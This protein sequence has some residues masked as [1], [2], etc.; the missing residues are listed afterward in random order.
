MDRERKRSH[1]MR[2]AGDDTAAMEAAPAIRDLAGTP[3]RRA[4]GAAH[5]AARTRFNFLTPRSK[6]AKTRSAGGA[7]QRG[8]I[9]VCYGRVS[10]TGSV[11]GDSL[12]NRSAAW[13]SLFDGAL[14]REEAAPASGKGNWGRLCCRGGFS[15][16][17]HNAGPMPLVPVTKETAPARAELGPFLMPGR[18]PWG[19]AG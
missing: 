15:R 8:I 5:P 13:N 4:C 12:V 11:L 6:T 14:P 1:W 18:R 3:R 16:R 9:V 7:G 19:E 17:G 2:W 10:A